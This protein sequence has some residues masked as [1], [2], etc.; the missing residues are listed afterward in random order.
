MIL[1]QYIHSVDATI[2]SHGC[3]VPELLNV[4]HSLHQKVEFA[5]TSHDS[6]ICLK[7]YFDSS[8]LPLTTL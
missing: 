4:L 2:L 1:G 7:L 6:E 5:Q 3:L 8:C